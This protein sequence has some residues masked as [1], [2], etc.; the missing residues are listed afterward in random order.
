MPYLMKENGM[1]MEQQTLATV[2]NLAYIYLNYGKTKRAIDYLLIAN[3]LSPNNLQVQKMQI[4]AFRD[5][6]AFPQALT[7]IDIVEKRSD[8]TELDKVTLKLMKSFC[9]KGDGKMDLAKTCF[10]EYI[11][12]RKALAKKDNLK[13]LQDELGEEDSSFRM[14]DDIE[15]FI[16]KGHHVKMQ[17]GSQAGLT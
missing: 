5:I 15:N 1:V 6:K 16:K 14:E 10:N 11:S 4:A 2:L 17:V 8:L 13:K 3:R 7:L 12:N 9:L